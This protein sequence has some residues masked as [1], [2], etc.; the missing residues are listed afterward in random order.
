MERP[1]KVCNHCLDMTR[2]SR[3]VCDTKRK[4]RIDQLLTTK[5][6]GSPKVS[7]D[8]SFLLIVASANLIR[9]CKSQCKKQLTA[10]FEM[11]E[12]W[13]EGHY[14]ETNG[15][16]G[17]ETTYD[18]TGSSN[19]INTWSRFLAKEISPYTLGTKL[20]YKWLKFN[21]FTR[22][23]PS[24]KQMVLLVFDPLPKVETKICARLNKAMP[25]F[26]QQHDHFWV[27]SQIL[28]DFIDVQHESIWALRGYVRQTEQ[29]QTENSTRP[30][31]RLLHDLARHSIHIC[32]TL[33]LAC[34]S[35]DELLEF[36]TSSS[37]HAHAARGSFQQVAATSGGEAA[38]DRLLFQRHVL[39]SFSLRAQANKERLQNEIGLAF[40]NIAQENALL[41]V[42]IGRATR[43]DG[44]AVKTVAFVTF[45]FLP[46]TL[47]CAIFSMPFFELESGTGELLVS[48]KFWM[49]WAVTIPVTLLSPLLWGGYNRLTLPKDAGNTGRGLIPWTIELR[50]LLPNLSSRGRRM[51]GGDRT[52]V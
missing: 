49:Y 46:A 47:I 30:N 2:W 51:Q 18:N 14:R 17:F 44:L 34:I 13:W 19:G 8:Y 22:W 45:A 7:V 24:T 6:G 26:N 11:P 38:R 9:D 40:N 48:N 41:A 16:F 4:L 15:Y 23:L 36:S 25:D 10:A 29:D 27:H 21:L 32:E 33:E 43:T 3:G 31:F 5:E 28:H 39:R 37:Q 35:M 50:E 42:E 1:K 52:E 12:M 20:E